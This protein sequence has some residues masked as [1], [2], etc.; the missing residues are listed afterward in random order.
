MATV[1]DLGGLLFLVSKAHHKKARQ[2]FDEIGLFRGQPP[3]LFEVSAHEGLTQNELASLL[4]V[5]P[6]TMTNLLQRIE[7]AGLIARCRD[8]KDL[9]SMRVYLTDKGR[10]KLAQSETLLDRM[11]ATAFAGFSQQEQDDFY[12]FLERAHT[13]LVNSLDD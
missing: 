7:E 11:N 6:A 5:T 4:E 12:Y 9:R 1:R 10:D 13:N 8:E 3:V 2:T